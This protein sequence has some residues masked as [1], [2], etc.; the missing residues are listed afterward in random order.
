MRASVLGRPVQSPSPAIAQAV[1]IAGKLAHARYAVLVHDAEPTAQGRDLLRAE[2]LIALAQALNTP[3][4]AA[5]S[6]L[7]A[8]GNRVGA[9]AVL[10]AQ[11]GYPFAVDYSRGYPRYLPGMR[12]LSRLATGAY[13]V[14]LVIGSAPDAPP[15]NRSNDLTTL[16]IGPR[17]SESDLQPRLAID[18]GVAGIHEAGI[19][20]RM[21]EV[22]LELRPPLSGPRSATDVVNRLADAVAVQLRSAS[23]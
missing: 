5:L 3:T 21:D 15:I 17:A 13:R 11:T 7:R 19:G 16:V 1:Q 4:R 18:T 23:Q 10:T 22:P 20:Y 6:S 2:A 12:G 9:E 14:L 8:G